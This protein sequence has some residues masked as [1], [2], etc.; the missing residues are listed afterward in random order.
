MSGFGFI[1]SA[2]TDVVNN[3]I[4]VIVILVSGI[5]ATL[6]YQVIPFKAYVIVAAISSLFI[7]YVL[8]KIINK[9][10]D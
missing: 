10:N 3:T 8:T 7:A 5:I 6:G 9:K 4:N 2:N 1:S